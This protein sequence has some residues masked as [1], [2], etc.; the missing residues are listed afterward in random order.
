MKHALKLAIDSLAA[1]AMWSIAA[2][3]VVG[4]FGPAPMFPHAW[5]VLCAVWITY[6][7]AVI[8]FIVEA[9]KAERAVCAYCGSGP[10]HNLVGK[11]QRR[12]HPEFVG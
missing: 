4:A 3:L 8:P 1:S 10:G 2:A 11:F 5:W 6:A 9:W 12:K 7:V